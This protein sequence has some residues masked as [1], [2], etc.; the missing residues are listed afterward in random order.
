MS[1]LAIEEKNLKMKIP[2]KDLAEDVPRSTARLV[3]PICLV[4]QPW[5][6]LLETHAFERVD[7]LI[8]LSPTFVRLGECRM[9]SKSRAATIQQLNTE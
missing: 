8:I 2:L 5:V 1:Q 9:H 3:K 6:E 7:S 4:L